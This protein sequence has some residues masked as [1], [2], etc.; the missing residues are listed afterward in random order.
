MANF[1]IQRRG[2]AILFY[3]LARSLIT[4]GHQ[5]YTPDVAAGVPA[6][7]KLLSD[8]RRLRIPVFCAIPASYPAA[9]DPDGYATAPIPSL[10]FQP[11]EIIRHAASGGFYG[12]DLETRLLSVSCSTL[13]VCGMSADRGV[14]MALREAAN[15]D[16]KPVALTDVIFAREL[17]QSSLGPVGASE[18]K[19]VHLAALE[20]SLACLMKSAEWVMELERTEP[21]DEC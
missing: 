20:R 3:D 7:E 5:Q 12:T 17:T 16:I 11:G 21:A 9:K 18:L 10:A 6:L 2:S 13:A 4:K 19:R 8:C 14:N 1:P 15:R